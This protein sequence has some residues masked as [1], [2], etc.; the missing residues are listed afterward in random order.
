[1]KAF[2]AQ[3]TYRQ[4]PAK[5]VSNSVHLR[6]NFITIDKGTKD[7]VRRDMGV[8]CGSGVV[9]IVYLC[10]SHY[11]V[12]IPV[13]NSKSN[14]SCKIQRHGY[15]GY[16]H[17]TGGAT[18]IAYV[19]D[20]PRH[21][22]FRIGDHVVTSGY[23]SVFPPGIL[24]GKIQHVYNSKDALSYRLQVK[25]ST[26]FGNLRDV[27][28]IDD[29]N[30]EEQLELLRT[31]CPFMPG[32]SPGAQPHPPLFIR[33]A[34][35]LCLHGIAL[36]A[37]LPTLGRADLVFL[38]G[39]CGRFFFQH[40]WAGDRFHDIL[41]VHPTQFVEALCATRCARRPATIDENAW[42]GILLLLYGHLGRSVHAVVLR[43]GG[44]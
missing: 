9:G 34:F 10:S 16:L 3:P 18:D 25:L 32:P 8:I 30:R 26:D 13:L 37:Q 42:C 4:I 24:V 33:D 28:V 19:D 7:G 21:A 23:S 22:H 2:P 17:W 12:V 38:H 36:S 44:I 27:F 14:I 20:I 15:F 43:I 35:A 5:V 41:G 39:T 11:S 29:E 40:T 1:M 31:V 6:D